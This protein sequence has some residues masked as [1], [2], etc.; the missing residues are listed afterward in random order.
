M[1]VPSPHETTHNDQIKGAALVLCS[2][3]TQNV[4]ATCAKHLFIAIGAAGVAALRIGLAALILMA[5]R[6]PWRRG[7]PLESWKPLILYG[8]GLGLMNLLFYQAFARIP[9]GLAIAIEVAGPVLI[10]LLGSRTL[11]DFLWIGLIITGLAFLL[12]LHAGNHLDPVGV[13]FAAGAG[14][15]W[16]FYVLFGKSVSARLGLDAP[17]WGMSVATVLIVPVGISTA[18]GTLFLPSV[19]FQGLIV[20]VL[21][22]ALPYSIEI[23]ALRLLPASLFSTFLSTSPAIG[24]LAGFFILGEHLT[25]LQLMAIICITTAAIGSSLTPRQKQV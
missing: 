4:G 24:S 16:V 1:P 21:S 22:S 19:L 17:A 23:K 13:L 12:P 10:S 9:I 6:R 14:L 3:I 8:A 5:F 11:K 18:G 15:C 25:M 2:L 20:A 7:F